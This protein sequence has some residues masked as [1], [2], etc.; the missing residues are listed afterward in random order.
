MIVLIAFSFMISGGSIDCCIVISACLK[1]YH[2]GQ[3]VFL[4]DCGRNMS[5]KMIAIT[6]LKA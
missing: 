5:A 1:F 3:P 6:N 4:F 2:S